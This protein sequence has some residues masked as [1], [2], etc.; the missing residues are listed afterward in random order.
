MNFFSYIRNLSNIGVVTKPHDW[1]QRGSK[2][3]LQEYLAEVDLF[4]G[5]RGA[6]CRPMQ[7][8]KRGRASPAAL[9]SLVIGKLFLPAD[10]QFRVHRLAED[11]GIPADHMPARAD[12]QRIGLIDHAPVLVRVR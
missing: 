12:N 9:S 3:G 1:F 4:S 11:F 5:L 2:S 8:K 7:T 10:L 6:S